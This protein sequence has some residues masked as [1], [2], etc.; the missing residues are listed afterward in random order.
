MFL[1]VVDPGV[2]TTRHPI[3]IHAGGRYYV[4]PDNGVFEAAFD[5]VGAETRVIED[6]FLLEHA[7]E[8]FHGRDLFAPVAA[9]IALRAEPAWRE[10]GRTLAAPAR[11]APALAEGADHTHAESL[12]HA[13]KSGRLLTRVA[14]VDRF[15]NAIT[16]LHELE[17]EAWLGDHDPAAIRFVARGAGGARVTEITGLARTYGDPGEAPIALVGSSGLIELALPGGHAGLHLGLAPGDVVE[18]RHEEAG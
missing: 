6:A 15:G 18:L 9:R 13:A 10:V 11:L 4:G 17:F 3:A 2:G 14:H 16:A 12:A 7:S 8:T 5:L 1:T